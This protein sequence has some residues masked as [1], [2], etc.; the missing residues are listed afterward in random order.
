MTSICI[1]HWRC[2]FWIIK[3]GGF[4][5]NILWHPVHLH[6]E[7]RSPFIIIHRRWC[8]FWI[9]LT[10]ADTSCVPSVLCPV[11]SSTSCAQFNWIIM[12][13]QHCLQVTYSLFVVFHVQWTLFGLSCAVNIKQC[14]VCSLSCEVSSLQIILLWPLSASE[15]LMCVVCSSSHWSEW[16]SILCTVFSVQCAVHLTGGLCLRVTIYRVTSHGG[17]AGLLST[18]TI[19]AAS[20]AKYGNTAITCET[21]YYCT[22]NVR[23]VAEIRKYRPIY[24]AGQEMRGADGH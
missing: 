1:V 16:P 20:V 23:G 24:R 15:Q 13:L 4:R 12:K 7:L 22:N 10:V 6:Y 14:T 9:G 3:K 5:L 18:E 2:Q 8:H 19:S 11:P 21:P 17:A